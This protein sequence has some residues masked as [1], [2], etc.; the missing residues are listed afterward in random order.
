M[1]NISN[2]KDAKIVNFKVV[3]DKRGNLIEVNFD[4]DLHF[5]VERIFFIRDVPS[6]DIRGQHAHLECHQLLVCIS[7]SVLVVADDGNKKKEFHLSKPHQGLYLPP[8]IWGEQYKYSIDAVLMVYA[9]HAYDEGD[10]IRNYD[11]YLASIRYE[12]K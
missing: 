9:S 12:K 1:K 10:Y 11:E 6:T 3:E 5:P 8:M 4:R 2:L 7:G